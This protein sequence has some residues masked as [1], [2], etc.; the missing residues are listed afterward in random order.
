MTIEKSLKR[1]SKMIKIL[2]DKN[3]L[4][5]NQ[6]AEVTASLNLLFQGWRTIGLL[7]E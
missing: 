7:L 1:P 5:Q 6:L 4:S 2:R 3:G